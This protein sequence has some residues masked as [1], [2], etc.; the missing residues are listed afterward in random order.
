MCDGCERW[1]GS[2]GFMFVEEKVQLFKRHNSHAYGRKRCYIY[3]I[4]GY[5]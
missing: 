4:L 2:W 1:H 5:R 3:W